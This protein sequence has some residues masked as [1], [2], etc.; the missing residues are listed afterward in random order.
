MFSVF[1]RFRVVVEFALI[2]WRFLARRL[3]PC[4]LL[5]AR[6]PESITGWAA[7][8][9]SSKGSLHTLRFTVARHSEVDFLGFILDRF[10]F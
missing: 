3:V 2:L 9:V 5:V 4:G 10:D 7:R 6:Q 1:S 8:I